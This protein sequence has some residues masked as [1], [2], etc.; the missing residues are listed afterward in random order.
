MTHSLERHLLAWILGALSVGAAILMFA[1]Y[2]VTLDEMD[3]MLDESLKQVA[4]AVAGEH[5]F[6]AELPRVR[7]SLPQ[8]PDVYEEHG[9]FDFVVL[10]WTRSGQLRFVSD[11]TVDLPFSDVNG[12]SEITHGGER[13][14]VYTIVDHDGVI[15]VAQRGSSRRTLAASTASKLLWPLV[16]LIGLTGVLLVA[17]LRR[18]LRPLDLAT[19]RVS[20]RS[21][22]SLDA[23]DA[24]QV[25]LE[26][27]PLIASINE[28]MLRLAEA[29]A[30]QRRFV[31]DA[32]HEL[33]SPITALRLQLQMLGRM[34]DLASVQ[35]ATTD[36]QAAVDRAQRL[37][38]QLLSLSRVEPDAPAERLGEVD[39]GELVREVVSQQ[40]I[41]AEEKGID[42]GAEVNERICAAGNRH[43]LEELLD[44]LVGNAI[45]YTPPGGTVDVRAVIIDGNPALQ[46][47]DSGP[48]IAESQRE[49][50]FDRFYR[51]EALRGDMRVSGSGLGLSIVRAIAE[52]HG[53]TVSL[54]TAPRGQ[55][56]EVRVL[57]LARTAT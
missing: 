50:V 57:F 37:I 31:A 48:G 20:A 21:A 49:R 55:G 17:A 39:L 18:G 7:K 40:S 42:L 22:S 34:R 53:A 10:T 28:L 25:P 16:M 43:Q 32:A 29:F 33:R 36:L 19:E 44:N 46:V 8:L 5:R 13:W 52:R 26:I 15:Q 1:S 24:D 45:R 4:L 54:H 30:A 35:H 3:E 11:S 41:A 51:G 14:H 12:V 9:N 23:I 27:R 2:V 56:L 38:E 47:V 6:D